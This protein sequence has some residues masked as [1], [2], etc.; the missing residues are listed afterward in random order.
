MAI[1]PIK[2]ANHNVAILIMNVEATEMSFGIFNK[3]N[4]PVIDASVAPNP[5]GNIAIEPIRVEKP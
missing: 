4:K 5:P 3:I 2:T 1:I